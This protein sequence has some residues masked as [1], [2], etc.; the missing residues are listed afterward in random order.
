M[1]TNDNHNSRARTSQS[2]FRD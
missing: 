2:Y 1:S